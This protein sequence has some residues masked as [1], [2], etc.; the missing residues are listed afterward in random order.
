MTDV[1]PGRLCT[2]GIFIR[3]AF[4]NRRRALVP[5]NRDGLHESRSAAPGWQGET[6][7]DIGHVGYPLD[8]GNPKM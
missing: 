6:T 7:E 8:S 4:S 3:A 2:S 1:E 5:W